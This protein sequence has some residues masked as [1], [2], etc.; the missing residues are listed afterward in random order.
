MLEI[1]SYG[2]NNGPIMHRHHLVNHVDMILGLGQAKWSKSNGGRAVFLIKHEPPEFDYI[3]LSEVT[4]GDVL[5]IREEILRQSLYATDWQQ[6]IPVH[7]DEV[8]DPKEIQSDDDIDDILD[9]CIDI[10]TEG[11]EDL[12][13]FVE[14]TTVIVFF[15]DWEYLVVDRLVVS[16][17]PN[18]EEDRRLP[19][20][21]NAKKHI[22]KL[23]DYNE[24]WETYAERICKNGYMKEYQKK[25]QLGKCAVCG[26]PLGARFVLHHVDY[27]HECEYGKTGLG[28]CKSG[29]ELIP[30]CQSCESLHHEWFELCS[31]G[32]CAV[33]SACNYYIDHLTMD[34]QFDNVCRS[35]NDQAK[36]DQ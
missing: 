27:D 26:K 28:F 19:V 17:R 9:L 3:R 36:V 29:K 33:H 25:E 20:V 16:K 32:L 11:A 10:W 5:R 1:D 4:E 12:S 13:Q 6:I 15:L 30:D 7:N 22:A 21:I 8:C 23:H 24:Y 34:R 2:I 18:Q 35:G 14:E 31:S